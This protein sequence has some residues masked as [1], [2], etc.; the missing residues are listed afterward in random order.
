VNR[1][2]DSIAKDAEELL[3]VALTEIDA[4]AEQFERLALT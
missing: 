2:N 1:I 3:R 4:P